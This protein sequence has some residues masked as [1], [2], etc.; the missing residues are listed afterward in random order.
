VSRSRLSAAL[1]LGLVFTSGVAVGGFGH[2][3]ASNT[4]KATSG[5]FSPEEY[6]RMYIEEMHSRLNLNKV[7]L[8][9]L[10]V[11]LDQTRELYKQL[12]DK[13]KPEFK[14]VQDLQVERIREILEPAQQ[15][16]YEKLRAERE[17]RRKRRD[18]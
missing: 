4:V 14:V 16:E 18:R 11:I 17:A 13:H 1:Y 10:G 2:W 8:E 3:Y 9:Q 5:K 15:A 6:R 12:Y 7:Q